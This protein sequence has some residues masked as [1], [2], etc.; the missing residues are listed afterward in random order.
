MNRHKKFDFNPIAQKHD[1]D[2][3]ESRYI[4]RSN[5]LRFVGS[6]LFYND[7]KKEYRFDFSELY[8]PATAGQPF[9]SRL[10]DHLDYVDTQ[11]AAA[12]QRI[13]RSKD[14]LPA[15][16]SL[17]RQINFIRH[18]FDWLRARG[19]YRLRDAPEELIHELIAELADGGWGRALSLESRW[20]SALDQLDSEGINF[21]D[22][23]HFKSERR[24]PHIETLR[25]SFWRK[26][27][28]WGGYAQITPFAKSRI[29][30]LAVDIPFSKAWVNRKVRNC[31]APSRYVLR[32][33]M[34]QINDLTTLP[35]SIDRLVNRA[36]NNTST[37]AKKLAQKSS[38]RTS[39][40]SVEDAVTLLTEAL[41]LLYEVAPPLI[42]LYEGARAV[43]PNLPASKRKKW[44]LGLNP[45]KERLEHALGKPIT[46][47]NSSAFSP[48]SSK[49]YAVEEVLG[50]VQGACAIILGAMNARR[51]REICDRN[52]GVRVGDL[53][54]LDNSL[55]LYQCWFYIEKTY[56]DRHLFYINQTSAD[57]LRCLDRMKRACVP[58]DSQVVAEASLFECGRFGGL[59]P[60]PGGHFAFVEDRNRSRSLISF[61]KFVYGNSETKPEIT[62]HMFRRFFAI[63]YYH[64]YEHAELRALKQHLRHLDIAMTRVYVTDPSTRALAEQICA[65]MGKAESHGRNRHLDNALEGESLDL[66]EALKEIG[67]EKLKIAVEQILD[68]APTAGGFSKIVRKLYRQMLSRIVVSDPNN[69]VTEQITGMLD[70]HGYRVKPMQHGQCHAPDIRRNLK[71][72]CEENGVL[73]REHATSRL[74]GRCPFHFNNEAYMKNLKEQLGELSSDMDDFILT[75][76]QQERANFEYQNLS[77][78]IILTERQ[79][80]ANAN[81]ITE[82]S[83][84][85][86]VAQT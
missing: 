75:P 35:P 56:R 34:G 14:G 79:M 76:Q 8:F 58:F 4:L 30:K 37:G 66:Q 21:A 19:I 27:L 62:S 32:N 74:C 84:G 13:D 12:D 6:T 71:G 53:I 10:S 64:R 77:K 63:L 52:H 24:T 36:T 38:S 82:L 69:A 46:N 65:A 22:A 85:G 7:G 3:A 55:G 54:I 45:L 61:F 39:N 25:Q 59:G 31:E 60:S 17:S 9:V 70:G 26:R 16:E 49:C 5:A 57:A 28:T 80:A 20:N 42:E 68:G 51:Q 18:V 78:L 86:K 40:I 1:S 44:L 48:K 41:T 81:T 73:A 15:A 50:A 11:L 43:F 47:W 29:E 2:I 67:R 83:G 72:A 23:F 33:M